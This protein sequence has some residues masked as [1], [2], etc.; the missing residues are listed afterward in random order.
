LRKEIEALTQSANQDRQTLTAKQRQ[1]AALETKS[2]DLFLRDLSSERE[3]R[4]DDNGLLKG[5]LAFSADGREVYFAGAM[6]SDTSSNEIYAMPESGKP[7]PLTSGPGFKSNPIAIPGG[8]YLVYTRPAQSPFP[9]PDAAAPTGRG[10]QAA[11]SAGAAGGRAGAGAQAVPPAGS[12][13]GRGGGG[14]GGPQNRRVE[15]A[16]LNLT[17]GKSTAFT[18]TAAPSISADGSA[19][20][21][22]GSN[23]PENNIQVL[24]LSEPLNPVT[25]KKS[26]DRIGSVALS[27]DS[28]LVTFEMP[29]THEKNTEIYCIKSDGTGEVRVSR[30][31]QPDWGPRFLTG[32]RILAIKG[33]RRHARSYIYDLDTLKNFK[34]FHNNTVRTIAPEYEWAANPAGNL[35]L[36]VAQRDG[37][38][39]SPERGVYFLNLNQKVTRDALLDRIRTNLASEQALHAAGEAMYRP[40]ADKVRATTERISITKL[41]EYQ[42]N[43]FSFDIKA[44]GQPGNKVAGDYLYNTF[45]SFGYQP[46]YEWFD[47]R[48][49]IRTANVVATLRG[50]E[51][52]ELVYV[53]G[54]HYDSVPAGPGADDNETGIA[55]LLESARVLAKTPMPATIIFAAFT[56]EEAG[57][58]GSHEFVRLAQGKKMQLTGAINNDM[59]GWTNDHRLDNLV[60]YTNEGMRDLQHAAAFLFSRMITY[61]SRYYKST[62]AAAFYDAYGNIVTGL[63]SYPLLGNPYYHQATDLLETVNQ[64]LVTE[65]AKMTTASLMLLASSPSPIKDLKAVSAPGGSIDLSWAASPEKGIK[66]Y[67]VAYGPAANP[68][69]R[70]M[71]VRIPKAKIIGMKKG[72]SVQVAV[73]AVN[74]QGLSSWDWAHATIKD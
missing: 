6:E 27:P 20:V 31:I 32:N 61:D 14:G 60:R 70:T 69:A 46:E 41:Y 30:E 55:V 16:I 65:A 39:I 36:I 12:G 53:V 51:N 56:G 7:R 21:F 52:P 34:L 54:S 29:W 22:L 28:S 15:F 44:I 45:S 48:G 10:G 50:T 26:Q 67:T 73:K 38:T 33:E 63:G 58:L 19:L 62:D 13:G 11:P 35:I 74:S 1:L 24:K 3:Q 23:G 4:L 40:I 17:D 2:M 71:T 59:I 68:M 5:G 49:S 9:R 37:D 47:A 72:E 64:Q 66:A 42:E 8:K 43:L 18:G 57:D 25:V